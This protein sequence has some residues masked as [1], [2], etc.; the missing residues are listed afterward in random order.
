MPEGLE[1]IASNCFASCTSLQVVAIPS[2]VTGLGVTVFNDCYN[3]KEVALPASL[4]IDGSSLAPQSV[5]Y[6]QAYESPY[7]YLDMFQSE[8]GWT[9]RD[10]FAGVRNVELPSAVMDQPVIAIEDGAFSTC[11]QLTSISIPKSIQQIGQNA[12][13]E[14]SSLQT[15]AIEGEI[16]TLPHG[17]FDGCTSLT[18]LSIPETVTSI[19]GRAFFLCVSLNELSLPEEVQQIGP[20]AFAGCRNLTRLDLP[21]GINDISDDVFMW[22]KSLTHVTIPNGIQHIGKNAFDRCASISSVNLPDSTLTIDDDAFQ[23]C[24]SLENLTIPENLQSIGEYAFSGCSKLVRLEIPA[25]TVT[26]GNNAFRECS[27]LAQLSLPLYYEGSEERLSIPSQTELTWIQTPKF[28]ILMGFTE[29]SGQQAPAIE[30]RGAPDS[31]L[32][33]ESAENISGPWI[34]WATTTISPDGQ[35]VI[36]I[37]PRKPSEFYR[38]AENN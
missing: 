1:S 6:W 34:P 28:Q 38:V 22:A 13:Y 16:K 4:R 7:W 12:F 17:M 35:S 37:D 14:C 18:T 32:T 33:I 19:G 24:S 29:Q 5:I 31:S 9:V 36:L 15:A 25:S 2:T 26:I 8:D 3:L 30:L 23:S 21:S 10:C 11:K 20:G 27:A